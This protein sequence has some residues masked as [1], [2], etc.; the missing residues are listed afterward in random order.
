MAG[1]KW[2]QGSDPEQNAIEFHKI[3]RSINVDTE[4]KLALALFLWLAVCQ[5]CFWEFP[6]TKSPKP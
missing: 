3:E 2:H 6:L 1:D 5:D 4:G